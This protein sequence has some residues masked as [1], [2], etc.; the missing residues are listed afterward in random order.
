ML[1]RE[2][3]KMKIFAAE[4]IGTFF[5]VFMGCG[6]I[7]VN[8]VYAGVVGHIGI[9]L[10]FGIVVMTLIYSLGNISGAHFNPAVTIG[11]FAAGRLKSRLLLTYILSQ[12]T[13][14]VLGA[15]LLRVLFSGHPDLGA[16]SPSVSIYQALIIEIVLTFLLMFV[17]LNV[18]TGHM[19]KGI[20]AGVAIGGTIALAALV[21]GPLTGASMNPA[22]SIGPALMSLN[23]DFIWL[24]IAGPVAVAAAAAPVVC[25][26]QGRSSEGACR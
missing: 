14:A 9:S 18:S 13:G 12:L 21:A 23:L 24:Y 10:A 8:D 22:R 4:A 7:V 11:F 2:T 15:A 26:L 3:G 17:I 25:F 5:L 1:D 6:A 16:T 19:E 20:M